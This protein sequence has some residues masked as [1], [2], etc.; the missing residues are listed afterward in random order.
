MIPKKYREAG[1]FGENYTNAQTRAQMLDDMRS[2]RE[3]NGAEDYSYAVIASY[4]PNK[5][6]NGM[7]VAQAAKKLRGS[8]ALDDQIEMILEIQ[9]RGGASAVFHS[10]DEQDLQRFMLHPNTMFASDSGV[11][12]FGEGVPHPRGYGN[13]AR[14]LARYVREL[15]LLRLE[16][17]IRRMASL[18]A[19]TF[20]IKNRGF[21][22][23]GC[24]ADLVV[25]DPAKV[26]DNAT[27]IAPHQYA[28][29]FA[30][31]FVNGV[32]VVRDDKHT[33]AKPGK[34]VRRNSD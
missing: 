12:R 11:R 21:I 14:I 34:P 3:R 6:L 22:R 33:G 20:G 26:Q 23:Q 17:T 9:N 10:I 7:N 28:T 8:D 25:F 29:G 32:E 24:W 13:N 18:P 31:V 27:F 19:T 15:N 5:S 16:D 30:R 4:R 2:R 1:K